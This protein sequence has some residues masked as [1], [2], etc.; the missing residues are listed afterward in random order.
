VDGPVVLPT[1]SLTDLAE[2]SNQGMTIQAPADWLVDLDAGGDTL[3]QIEIPGTNLL[4]TIEVDGALEFPSLLGVALFRSQAEL[5]VSEFSAGAQLVESTTLHSTQGLPIAKLAF[6][7]ETEGAASAGAFYVVAPNESAYLL[8]A[9]G[10]QEEWDY[11]AAGVELIAESI[12]FD[13]ELITVT[14]AGDEPLVYTDGNE[15]LEVE[16]PAGWYVIDT[17]DSLFPVVLAEPEVRY[18]AAVGTEASF[19]GDLEPLAE[20]VPAEGD[21]DAAQRDELIAA[22][23]DLMN[24][25]GNEMTVDEEQSDVF[26]REGA[27]MVRLVGEAEID[28]GLTMPVVIYTD[29][30]SAGAAVVALF[31]DIDSILAE[32][33]VIFSL[34]ESVTE[35]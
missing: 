4:L 19:G 1:L 6:S 12:T 33:V 2:Y 27:V 11:A 15:T 22:V 7:E 14:S 29:L 34:V 10:T 17:G 23:V 32:E 26:P 16:V 25:A 35:L 13:E 9:G 30:R 21:F 5:L 3:F 31:G 28:Q 24:S 8:L 20:F 18:I